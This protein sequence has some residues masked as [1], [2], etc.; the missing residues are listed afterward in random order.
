MLRVAL[1]RLEANAGRSLTP[2]TYLVMPA[3]LRTSDGIVR[4]VHSHRK[5]GLTRLWRPNA[6]WRQP[7][8]IGLRTRNQRLKRSLPVMMR[9]SCLMWPSRF[10]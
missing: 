6:R 4:I 3:T 7:S 8:L 10:R 1:H 2:F 5:W 9:G